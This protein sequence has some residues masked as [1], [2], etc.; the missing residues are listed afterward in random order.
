MLLNR[1]NS[2]LW[3]SELHSLFSMT[4]SGNTGKRYS[5]SAEIHIGNSL[6]NIFTYA[7][8]LHVPL[9]Y[10]EHNLYTKDM[11]EWTDGRREGWTDLLLPAEYYLQ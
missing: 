3:F 2:F 1:A 6:I 11:G 10:N 4:K 5:L 8:F 7:T 9:T